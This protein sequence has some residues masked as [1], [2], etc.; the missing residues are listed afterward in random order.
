LDIEPGTVVAQRYRIQ[1]Q[2]GRGGMGEVFAAE[3]VRTGRVVAVKLLRA[4]T[5]QKSS[6]VARFRR[7]A[8]AAGAINS[9]YVTQVLDVEEDAEHGIVI[10]F[11]LLEGESLIDR[12]KRTGPMTF[13]ELFPIVEQVWIG[14]AD[15]H[16]A[17]VI[18]RDLKPSNVFLERR[19]DGSSRVKIL[20][21][22]ISKLPREVGGETLT[23]MGQSL[24]TFSF[25]PPEQIGKA[26]TVDHRADVYACATLIYQAMS[27]QLPYAARNILMMVELKSKADPRPLSEV[28]DSPVDPQLEAFLAR[29]LKRDPQDRYQSA[30][31]AL[32]AWRGLRAT[33]GGLARSGERPVAGSH[34]QSAMTPGSAAPNPM[35]PNP[36]TPNPMTPHPVSGVSSAMGQQGMAHAQGFAAPQSTGGQGASTVAMRRADLPQPG[37][38]AVPRGA[39]A[40]SALPSVADSTSEGSDNV[41]TIAIPMQRVNEA[42]AARAAQGRGAQQA[43]AATATPLP[44]SVA[45]GHA[46][47]QMPQGPRGLGG[48]AIVHNA[49][50]L[51]AG[52]PGGLP[53]MHDDHPNSG[54]QLMSAPIIAQAGTAKSTSG[55]HLPPARPLSGTVALPQNMG[56]PQ[57]LPTPSKA[58]GPFHDRGSYDG[59][60]PDLATAVYRRD[61]TGANHPVVK[62]PEERK[63]SAAPFI[64]GMIALAAVGFSLVALIL[65]YV[66]TGKLPWR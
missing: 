7:E 40:I 2:L 57:S 52:H 6:A 48:T 36:M 65:N 54:T 61:T 34:P 8:R 46:H 59:N 55:L 62:L 30:V 51:I 45:Q 23:E 31:E 58:A 14:L 35:T 15:A 25:M 1:R 63:K 37:F 28:M 33:M 13:D 26:K 18:H 43:Q 39:H 66:Q 22:G 44:P 16:K 24:G 4:D 38:A 5:K 60:A 47:Q 41:A 56:T 21:F 29:C 17:G 32:E 12:L 10:V 19:P 42:L 50:A 53:R 11:E 64:L 9:D 49:P 27:G 20:D 3:N